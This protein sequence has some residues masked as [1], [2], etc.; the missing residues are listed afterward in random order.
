MRSSAATESSL[1]LPCWPP[2]VEARRH[3]RAR[4]RELRGEAHF[5]SGVGDALF[6][7]GS[8]SYCSNKCRG[9]AA[10]RCE[11][12]DAMASAAAPPQ[13]LPWCTSSTSN[14]PLDPFPVRP[15][16]PTSPSVTPTSPLRATATSGRWPPSTPHPASLISL[17]TH[18]GSIRPVLG[19]LV[20][21]QCV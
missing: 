16:S 13:G 14:P 1:G 9:E 2:L 10:Q 20:S 7:A 12:G 19:S 3:N 11:G 4:G 8:R 18:L 15:S 21:Y 6:L 17:L 5:S